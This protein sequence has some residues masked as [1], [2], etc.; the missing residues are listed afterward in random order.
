MYAK[1]DGIMLPVFLT[2]EEWKYCQN[3]F[4]KGRN[5]PATE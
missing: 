3:V 2:N 5:G 1:W 4:D